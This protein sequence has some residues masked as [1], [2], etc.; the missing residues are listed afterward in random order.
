MKRV[1]IYLWRSPKA[2]KI[3]HP[4]VLT[5]ASPNCYFAKNLHKY[6]N[7][8]AMPLM[9]VPTQEEISNP[10]FRPRTILDQ[11]LINGDR[12]A[13]HRNKF[14]FFKRRQKRI[15]GF[16]EKIKLMANGRETIIWIGSGGDGPSRQ[17]VKTPRKRFLKEIQKHFTYV[18]PNG[19][20]FYTSA[21]TNCCK[22]F[23]QKLYHDDGRVNNEKFVCPQC[24]TLWSRDISASRNQLEI[25]IS[26]H[27]YNE[28]PEAFR[29]PRR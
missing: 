29:R 11:L 24:Q 5:H 21:K 22:V 20:E 10:D 7:E 13:L 14:D 2:R 8:I 9:W 18:K 26:E 4:P 3:I 23:N 16:I 12:R 19:D 17:S 1:Y 25:A 15:M 28:R 6:L 27:Y